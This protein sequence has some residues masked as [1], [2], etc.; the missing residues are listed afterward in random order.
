MKNIFLN[1]F[2]NIT[3]MEQK[4]GI[5]SQINQ[6]VYELYELMD[7]EIAIVE[8]SVNNRFLQRRLTPLE[9]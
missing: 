8:S 7:E 9:L 3:F 1:G 4:T 6:L 5:E 2:Y